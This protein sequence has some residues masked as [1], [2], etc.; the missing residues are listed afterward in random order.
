VASS[1]EGIGAG[2]SGRDQIVV[3]GRWEVDVA[4]AVVYSIVSDFSRMPEHFPKVARSV[5]VVSRAGDRLEL[6]VE[7]ASFGRLF[8]PVRIE[9]TAD[10]LPGEGYRCTTHNLT[11]HTTG[12]EELLLSDLP[13][14]R[15]RIDYR[16]LVTL[17]HPRMRPVY[18]WLTRTFAL[19]YWK[20]AVVD[21]LEPIARGRA[22]NPGPGGVGPS[23]GAGTRGLMHLIRITLAATEVDSMR[24]FYD[25]VLDTG[26]EPLGGSPLWRGTLAGIE[27]V[28]C[29]NDLAGVDARQNRHQLRLAV[30]DPA[31]SLARVV[32]RGGRIVD[33]WN[34]EVGSFA[35]PDG[36]TYELVATTPT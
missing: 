17:R 18:A 29:P 7:A 6:A 25:S 27:V 14:G 28:L 21:R 33:P 15:T 2:T 1:G 12:D 13:G 35:D 11:F 24:A 32:E 8:P 30:A 3:R 31:G 4:R 26:F 23:E 10:L 20:R 36:N 16:Y 5:R 22:T 19:R 34:G 9:M